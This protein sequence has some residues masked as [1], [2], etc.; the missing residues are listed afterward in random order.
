[1]PLPASASTAWTHVLTGP[2]RLLETTRDFLKLLKSVIS[3]PNPTGIKTALALDWYKQP[4]DG[5]DA[6][7]WPNT[8]IGELVS[9]GKYKYPTHALGYGAAGPAVDAGRQGQASHTAAPLK[10]P[11]GRRL[12]EPPSCSRWPVGLRGELGRAGTPTAPR[13]RST[14]T[15]GGFE[16]RALVGGEKRA[17]SRPTTQ[18]PSV[19]DTTL[20]C[21]MSPLLN[22]TLRCETST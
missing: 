18:V 12:S 17:T 9:K 2:T 6:H 21:S 5:L 16:P 1:V 15:E 3:L 14:P 20:P 10:T 22:V 13:G 7:S 19:N 4:I 11:T 8:G